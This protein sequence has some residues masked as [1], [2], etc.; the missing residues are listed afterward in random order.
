MKRILFGTA[1]AIVLASCLSSSVIVGS[2]HEAKGA[3][4]IVPD[5]TALT[6]SGGILVELVDTLSLE[7]YIV[8]DDEVLEH[9]SIVREDDRVKV[10]YE[11]LVS[12]RTD[13]KTVV[14][15]PVSNALTQLEASSAAQVTSGG[16][17]LAASMDIEC[18][19][20]ARVDLDMD[21]QHLKLELSNAAHFSGNVVARSL[22]AE[23]GNAAT[24]NI[25]GSA[26]I[27]GIESAN[28]ANFSGYGLICRRVGAN[29]SSGGNID[30]SVTQELD[31]KAS[32]GGAVRYKGSPEIVHRRQSG[33]GS[34]REVN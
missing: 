20:A 23:L 29:A 25:E 15:M 12:V 6:V 14:A 7:G 30:I 13:I 26:D 31:A 9:V 11:P 1:I 17:L 27:C 21:V 32:S 2:G 8:A 10:S 22:E 3:F 4:D 19:S 28:D 34:V 16:R 18:S 33:G 24:I 5:Y